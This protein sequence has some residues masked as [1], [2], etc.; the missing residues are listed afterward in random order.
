VIPFILVGKNATPDMLGFVP[1]FFDEADPRPAR[2]QVDANYAH[3][4]GWYPMQKV[5]AV[6]EIPFAFHYPDD[7]VFY[8]MAVAKLRQEIIVLYVAGF[9][10]IWQRDGSFE[11]SRVD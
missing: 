3:G 7:P 5:T 4:G 2:E 8:P 9:L 6:P 10:G 1:E 11:I